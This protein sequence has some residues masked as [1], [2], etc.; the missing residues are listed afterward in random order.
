MKL[1]PL[2]VIKIDVKNPNF[3]S[4]DS[5]NNALY[6]LSGEPHDENNMQG[7]QKI[8]INLKDRT[9]KQ[10]KKHLVSYINPQFCSCLR[11]NNETNTLAV[12][13]SYNEN[14][15]NSIVE[16]YIYSFSLS[17]SFE[18]K[19]E[20]KISD[21]G[22]CIIEKSGITDPPD[23]LIGLP[24]G[25]KEIDYRFDYEFL[26]AKVNDVSAMEYDKANKCVYFLTY[27]GELGFIKNK[28]ITYLKS[29]SNFSSSLK[30]SFDEASG[31]IFIPCIDGDLVNYNESGVAVIET[32]KNNKSTI[33]PVHTE[34]GSY[35]YITMDPLR[36]IVYSL[37]YS[38]FE[39]GIIV[40]AIDALTL[41][42]IGHAT[43]STPERNLRD[44]SIHLG[45]KY[46]TL[47][48]LAGVDDIL[49]VEIHW[50]S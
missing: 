35:I 20:R 15:N 30:M 48:I 27:Y 46:S 31:N 34:L 16:P 19:N 17:K 21:E 32:R 38:V 2:N 47:Y 26:F 37:S 33:I 43:I 40:D 7:L 28:E 50:D 23:F 41:D 45:E 1:T 49:P 8:N 3:I 36:S 11:V 13:C 14:G 6:V 10:I 44:A 18:L 4:C 24:D 12:V 25:I 5:I 29:Y 39:K 9:S 22:C 42:I